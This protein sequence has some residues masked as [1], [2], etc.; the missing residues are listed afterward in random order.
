[1]AED[2]L[3]YRVNIDEDD[4]AI[5]LDRIRNQID[6]SL[7]STAM[8]ASQLPG[9]LAHFHSNQI[10]AALVKC[11][12]SPSEDVLVIFF[13]STAETTQLGFS[14]FTDDM[15][16][17]GLLSA[18][19]HPMPDVVPFATGQ[20]PTRSERFADWVIDNTF[21]TAGGMLGSFAGIPGAIVGTGVGMGLDFGVDLAANRALQRDEMAGAFGQIARQS[22]GSITGYQSR[23]LA[24]LVQDR[25][26]SFDG[27]M[28][29]LDMDQTQSNIMH[30]ANAGGFTSAGSADQMS[31]ILEGVIENTRSFADQLGI[32][33]EQAATIM[34]QLEQRMIASTSEVSGIASRLAMSGDPFGLDAAD[35]IGT[36]MQGAEMVRGSGVTAQQ[37]FEM[38][39]QARMQVG[40]LMRSSDPVTRQVLS[41]FASP[42]QAAIASMES[43][44]RYMLSGQGMLTTGAILGGVTSPGASL[45]ERMTALSGHIGSDPMNMIRM[46]VDGPNVLNNMQLGEAQL[47]QT[48]MAMEVI[49]GMNHSGPIDTSLLQSVFMTHQNMSF[50]DAQLLAQTAA[51]GNFALRSPG[52]DLLGI[53]D[54]IGQD[55]SGGWRNIPSAVFGEVGEGFR[56]FFHVD[57]IGEAVS[58]F[59]R[60][61]GRLGE[62]MSDFFL[63]RVRQRGVTAPNAASHQMMLSGELQLD[64]DYDAEELRRRSADGFLSSSQAMRMTMTPS[65]HRSELSGS[66]REAFT[67]LAFGLS[68]NGSANF[69]RIC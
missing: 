14:K 23:G 4:L 34:A 18:P 55:Q 11:K 8:G 39:T 47:H 27:R 41:S 2:E 67:D 29:G 46:A 45:P 33:Q 21:A 52:E 69:F 48:Q 32:A 66:Y 15:R 64:S 16:R 24:D 60:G 44:M 59:R 57:Q 9:F 65:G 25:V 42:E 56:E 31:E 12:T 54:S 35:L 30:F 13:D 58:S 61:V 28:R 40:Q 19:H 10:L 63:G 51:E 43:S 22:F 62:D 49:R 17:V 3:N 37:G 53:Y 6:T 26:H 50:R 20:D 7:G 68:E 5:Q 38:A 1:M 36:G